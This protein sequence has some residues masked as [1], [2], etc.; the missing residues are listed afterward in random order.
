MDLFVA[1]TGPSA[2]QAIRVARTHPSGVGFAL[3]GGV[4]TAFGAPLVAALDSVGPVLVLSPLGG[5]ADA[6]GRAADRLVRHGASWIT[7]AALAGEPAIAAAVAACTDTPCRVAVTAVSGEL[8]DAATARLTGLTKRGKLVSRL[9]AIGRDAGADGF[10]GSNR[11][12][13][14]VAQVA[15]GL[16]FLSGPLGDAAGVAEAHARAASA[17]FTVSDPSVRVVEAMLAATGDG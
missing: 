17:A 4:L 16:A 2:E 14:V 12:I 11:D 8:D 13:G 5:D 15:P 6:V 10:V 9:A 3:D 7:V 1:L